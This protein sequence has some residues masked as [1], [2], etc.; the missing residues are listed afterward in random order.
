MKMHAVGCAVM[1]GVV[2]E[3]AVQLASRTGG[4]EHARAQNGLQVHGSSCLTYQGQYSRRTA[5]HA[6][7]W[8][9]GMSPEVVGV[10]QVQEAA[11]RA[12]ASRWDRHA[13]PCALLETVAT[14]GETPECL[15][16]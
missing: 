10:E 5:L 6:A 15:H 7:G 2:M 13:S 12:A 1:A 9:V 11:C 4:M 8:F 14:G 16:L 3:V